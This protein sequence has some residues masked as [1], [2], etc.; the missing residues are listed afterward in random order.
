MIN[1]WL[2]NENRTRM[3]TVILGGDTR[4][5]ENFFLQIKQKIK[6][7]EIFHMWNWAYNQIDEMFL[8]ATT[9]QQPNGDD[10]IHFSFE[11]TVESCKNCL[12]FSQVIFRM[13]SKCVH[14]L[15]NQIKSTDVLLRLSIHP[16]KKP[17]L[18]QPNRLRISTA[19]TKPFTLQLVFFIHSKRKNGAIK[20]H[21]I[22]HYHSRRARLSSN[23][24][25]D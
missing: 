21:F 19:L 3:H 10:I 7:D 25:N 16:S 14:L 5:R 15:P 8:S 22:H 6:N 17:A 1:K 20:T 18:F 9:R 12:H 4:G 13:E 23:K 24:W 11:I 2:L